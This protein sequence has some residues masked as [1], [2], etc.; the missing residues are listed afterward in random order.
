MIGRFSLTVKKLLAK[1][2]RHHASHAR[3]WSEPLRPE[4]QRHGC[5]QLYL[6]CILQ[7]QIIFHSPETEIGSRTSFC[8][9]AS[10]HHVRRHFRCHFGRCRCGVVA[11]IS[12]AYVSLP[13]FHR[14]K[15]WSSS[16]LARLP[17]SSTYFLFLQRAAPSPPMRARHTHS[18]PNTIYRARKRKA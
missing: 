1:P 17:P 7:Q 8:H 16:S 12:P 6:H 18:S 14:L 15:W 10:C 5:W 13:S 3:M 2:C 9:N 4:D 11:P